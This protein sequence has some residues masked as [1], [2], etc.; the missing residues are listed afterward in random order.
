MREN[1][2]VGTNRKKLRGVTHDQQV[3]PL[4]CR[5]HQREVI[6]KA[7]WYSDWDLIPGWHVKY[8]CSPEVTLMD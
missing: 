7:T 5:E 6:L 3:L 4:K 8:Q 2:D 1:N